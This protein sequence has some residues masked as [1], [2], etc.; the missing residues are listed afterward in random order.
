MRQPS[1]YKEGGKLGA[2]AK[3]LLAKIDQCLQEMGTVFCSMTETNCASPV[4]TPRVSSGLVIQKTLSVSTRSVIRVRVRAP[5]T[6]AAATAN[7]HAASR[8]DP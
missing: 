2:V 6:T 5:A 3:R 8:G 4:T 7:A 1:G